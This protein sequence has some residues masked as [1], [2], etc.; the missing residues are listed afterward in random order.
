MVIC[1]LDTAPV[2]ASCSPCSAMHRPLSSASFSD[3][4]LEV[5]SL[6]N[7]P[8]SPSNS[9]LYHLRC[10]S[11]RGMRT[12]VSVLG[13]RILESTAFLV[14]RSISGCSSDRAARTAESSPKAA[15][16]STSI[17]SAP[18]ASRTS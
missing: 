7:R 1:W 16:A 10:S 18:A 5:A 14:R 6:P 4:A 13:G 3:V 12:T 2:S 11:D 9:V 8:V 17:F 15:S